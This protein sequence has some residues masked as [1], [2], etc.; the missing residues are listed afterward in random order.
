MK[1]CHRCGSEWKSEKKQPAVKEICSEC[2]AFLHCCLNCR[3]Y[4]PG[5]HN[6]C[7]IGT[8]E[9]V[10]DK[11]ALNFCDEFE[12]AEHEVATAD[13]EVQREAR[14]AFE[15]LFGSGSAREDRSVDDLKRL[16]G[17]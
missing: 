16:F 14:E 1:H 7:H 4:E 13:R 15:K 12:F 9:Y 11:E 5:V 2:S 3:F 17:D 8:T 6:D 10:S